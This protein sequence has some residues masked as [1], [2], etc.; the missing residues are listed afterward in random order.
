MPDCWAA[1]TGASEVHACRVVGKRIGPLYKENQ[2][3]ATG[4]PKSDPLMADTVG[5]AREWGRD[6]CTRCAPSLR[7]SLEA[8]MLGRRG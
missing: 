6:F 4:F 5:E 1:S 2:R 3:D 8:G 7:C